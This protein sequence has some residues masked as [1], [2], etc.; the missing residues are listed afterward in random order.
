MRDSLKKARADIGKDVQ[1]IKRLAEAALGVSVGALAGVVVLL[2][3]VAG[4]H[5]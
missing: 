4:G 1:S 5:T 3:M 2:A